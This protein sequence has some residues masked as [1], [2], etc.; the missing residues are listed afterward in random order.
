MYSINTVLNDKN[1][2]RYSILVVWVTTHDPSSLIALWS[3]GSSPTA[4]GS[5]TGWPATF[6]LE[7]PSPDRIP[8]VNEP[9]S[10]IWGFISALGQLT[11]T[12]IAHHAIYKFIQWINILSSQHR[13]KIIPPRHRYNISQSCIVCT[14]CNLLLRRNACMF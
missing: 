1:N 11:L 3:E 14:T 5:G 2:K 7:I 9:R 12:W 6:V 8:Q 13:H 10:F 4:C